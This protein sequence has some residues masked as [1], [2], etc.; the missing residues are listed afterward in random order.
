M[1]GVFYSPSLLGCKCNESLCVKG[2]EQ[3]SSMI[4]NIFAIGNCIFCLS[5]FL[6]LLMFLKVTA[7]F[8]LFSGKMNKKLEDTKAHYLRTTARLHKLHNDYI[9]AIQVA[10]LHQNNYLTSLLPALLTCHRDTHTHL[11]EGW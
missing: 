11:T 3:V 7:I 6:F 2:G 9:I 10:S 4:S 1:V 5:F 8:C